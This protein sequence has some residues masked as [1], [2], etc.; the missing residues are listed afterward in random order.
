MV[1]YNSIEDMLE[2]CSIE[3][4]KNWNDLVPKDIENIIEGYIDFNTYYFEESGYIGRLFRETGKT[5][6]K[7]GKVKF[8]NVSRCNDYG[9]FYTGIV[10][11]Y[12]YRKNGRLI[13]KGDN[14][15]NGHSICLG[16][17]K[18]YVSRSF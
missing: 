3:T 7:N 18:N 15:K 1:K 17:H 13:F 4:E 8:I 12:S 5:F 14:M 6:Y 2:N 9:V 16:Y 10:Q 11:Q